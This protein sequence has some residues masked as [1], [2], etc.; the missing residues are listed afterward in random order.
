M[1]FKRRF[2]VAVIFFSSIV[3]NSCSNASYGSRAGVNVTWGPNGPKVRPHIDFDIF[4]GGR[5]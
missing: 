2:L 5:L 4:N 1:M 3:F